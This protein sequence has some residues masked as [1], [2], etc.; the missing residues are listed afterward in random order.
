MD[1][2]GPRSAL[3]PTLYTTVLVMQEVSVSDVGHTTTRAGIRLLG[4]ETVLQ[5][6]TPPPAPIR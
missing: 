6:Q 2:Q 1:L 5:P 4:G 3:N